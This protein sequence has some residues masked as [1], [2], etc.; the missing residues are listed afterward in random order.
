ME[1]PSPLLDLGTGPG[2]PGIPLKIAY[3]ELQIFFAESRQK[4]VDFPEN[5][6]GAS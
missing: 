4:R 2:M 6:P 5:G 3:P 1:L